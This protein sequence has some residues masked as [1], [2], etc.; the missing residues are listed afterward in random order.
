MPD[1]MVDEQVEDQTVSSKTGPGKQP[2]EGR[3]GGGGGLERVTVNLA[4]RASRALEKAVALT[5]DS[6][7]DT[8]NRALQVYAY[9]EEVWAK[10]GQVLVRSSPDDDQ[11]TV[12][13]FF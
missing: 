3:G 2:P 13:Q 11:V 6:K 4:P 1:G 9:L 8:I 12:L 10:N 7:T 5:G